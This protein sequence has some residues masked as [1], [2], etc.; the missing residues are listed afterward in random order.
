MV[1][2]GITCTGQGGTYLF[3]EPI[4]PVCTM[5]MDLMPQIRYDLQELLE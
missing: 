2:T 1:R 5:L 4:Q 3:S